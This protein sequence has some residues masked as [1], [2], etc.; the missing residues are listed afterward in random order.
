ME[1]NKE[2]SQPQAGTQQSN[3]HRKK[4][5]ITPKI[6]QREAYRVYDSSPF[7]HMKNQNYIKKIILTTELNKE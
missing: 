2:V 6:G 1:P 5:D 7:D 4:D 3:I